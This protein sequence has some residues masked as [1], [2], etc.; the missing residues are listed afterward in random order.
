MAS[1]M[2]ERIVNTHLSS[3]AFM[4]GKTIQQRSFLATNGGRTGRL[5]VNANVR[6]RHVKQTTA[7]KIQSMRFQSGF[8][9][10]EAQDIEFLKNALVI[11]A[12]NSPGSPVDIIIPSP[13]I[14]P[15]HARIFASEGCLLIK[16]LNSENGTFVD[17][18]LVKG[19]RAVYPGMKVSF[20]ADKGIEFI[21]E[22][23][24]NYKREMTPNQVADEV[25]SKEPAR[26]S[27]AL[28][29]NR[30]KDRSAWIDAFRARSPAPAPAPAADTSP[31]PPASSEAS[32]ED[33]MQDRSAWI[34]AYNVKL[35]SPMAS[36]APVEERIKDRSAWIDTHNAKTP[37][38][39]SSEA[40]FED[41]IKDRSA[42]IAS[43]RAGSA[44]SPMSSEASYE[45]R[46][47]DRTTWIAKYRS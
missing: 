5:Q 22:I 18:T 46:I 14:S 45:D 38:A 33:R 25:A 9:N 19:T 35:P 31:A 37:S 8:I 34:A 47:Q 20:D 13:V 17:G 41:R 4:G 2:A 21:V 30:I 44:P 3:R 23:D 7:Q 39:M 32:L 15:V 16:D 43:Y 11:G 1:F 12:T 36:E 40:S 29:T 24:P 42:W 26:S 28:A 10:Y 27:K 6:L